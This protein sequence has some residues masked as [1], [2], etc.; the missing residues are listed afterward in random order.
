MDREEGIM[1]TEKKAD[2]VD[3]ALEA[4]RGGGSHRA[5]CLRGGVFELEL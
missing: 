2:T 1:R 3:G 4:K 5:V